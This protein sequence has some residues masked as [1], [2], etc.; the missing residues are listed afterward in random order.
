MTKPDVRGEVHTASSSATAP[1][2]CAGHVLVSGSYGGEYNAWHA[3]RRPLR[4][5][6]LN[7]AGVGKNGAGI[8]GL[9]YLDGIG[10]PAATAD[11]RTCHIGDG[12]HMLAH[13]TISH[14]NAAAATLGCRPGQSVR[15]CAEL[16]RDAPVVEADLPPIAG[17]KRHLISANPGEPKVVALDAAPL[18]QPDD[19]GSIVI[20]GSH[21]ALFRGQPDNVIGPTLAAVFFNDAGVGLDGAGI[22]RLD[23]LDTRG[24]AAG[25]VS[26]DT[27]PIG[28]ARASFEQGILS[29]LNSTAEALGGRPG[30]PLKQFV[31]LLVKLT[32]HER[33]AHP[34]DRRHRD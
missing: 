21:A 5:V 12:E 4:G 6:I 8:G 11:A 17:G 26:A 10:L 15:A 1:D 9:P 34:S 24:I 19:E 7:D 16:M 31:A 30:M 3:A 32:D 27:A 2:A 18:L 23:D 33:S 22:R 25:A 29:H 13:G 28:D 14:V 20:T